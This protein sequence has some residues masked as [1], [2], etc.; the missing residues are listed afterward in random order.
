MRCQILL[1]QKIHPITISLPTF[2][3]ETNPEKSPPVIPGPKHNVF[4]LKMNKLIFSF[5]LPIPFSVLGT[6]NSSL[7]ITICPLMA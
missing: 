1:C 7:P 6:S 2:P 4:V 3:L 5:I